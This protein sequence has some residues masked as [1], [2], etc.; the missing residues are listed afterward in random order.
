MPLTDTKCK[1]AKPKE[2]AYKLSDAG[3]LFLFVT[4]AGNKIWRMKYRFPKGGKEKTLVF[5]EYPIISL[6]EAREK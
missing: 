6:L 2:K 4:K 5:G 3:G 1:N